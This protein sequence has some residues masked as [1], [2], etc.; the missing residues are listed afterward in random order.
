MSLMSINC[1]KLNW[2]LD[3][4]STL[5]W[6]LTFFVK[7]LFW[8]K[9]YLCGII[10]KICLVRTRHSFSLSINS[11]NCLA[12]QL[13]LLVQGQRWNNVNTKIMCHWRLSR[14][15]ILNFEQISHLDLALQL[16]TLNKQ[17]PTSIRVSWGDWNILYNIKNIMYCVQ[18]CDIHRP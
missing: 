12:L 13:H 5:H 3:I 18:E 7:K 17:M 14:V 9:I 4:W 2:S 8:I 1:N 6:L 10:Y 11:R 15:F 16:L